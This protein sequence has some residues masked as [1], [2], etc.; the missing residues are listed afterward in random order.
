MIQC[1]IEKQEQLPE[2]ENI[3]AHSEMVEILSKVSYGMVRE[4]QEED[5]GIS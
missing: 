2:Q 4:A 5:V 3:K 1:E